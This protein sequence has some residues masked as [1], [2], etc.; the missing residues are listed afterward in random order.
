MT[1]AVLLDDPAISPVALQKA[2]DA[3]GRLNNRFEAEKALA[4]LRQKYPDFQK[5]QKSAKPK[6]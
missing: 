1:V 5:S 3:Y 2:A 4:Q 6:P